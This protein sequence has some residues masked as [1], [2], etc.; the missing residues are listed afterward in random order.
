M[1]SANYAQVGMANSKTMAMQSMQSTSAVQPAGGVM[2]RLQDL[3]S[4][5]N[6]IQGRLSSLN[7]SLRGSRP[8]TGAVPP[9]SITSYVTVSLDELQQLLTEIS[10]LVSEQYRVL[11]I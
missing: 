7:D 10:D 1:L 6:S 11:G 8:E 3:I 4:L 5:A 9:K 2:P